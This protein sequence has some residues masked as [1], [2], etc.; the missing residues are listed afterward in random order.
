MKQRIISAVFIAL[1]TIGLILIGG[2]FFKLACF[3]IGAYV[4]REFIM[5]SKKEFNI[6]LYSIMFFTIAMILLFNEYANIIVIIEILFLCT[7]FVN[8]E[9][10]S[11]S[12][13][14][15]T[16]LMSLLIGFGLYFLNFIEQCSRLLTA[17]IIIITYITDVFALFTGMKFGKHKLNERVSPKKTIEGAIGGWLFGAILSFVFA[18]LFDFFYLNTTLIVISSICLPIVSQIGDLVFSAIKRFY[19]VK[20]FSNL[21]PG[22]GGLLDRLD[23]TFFC[24]VFFGVLLVLAV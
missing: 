13:A 21:I 2:N 22:H 24:V 17:Y 9:N 11:F 5:V 18:Y 14:S 4:T 7:L 23:S 3:I 1:T 8:D 12:D 10:V 16:L 20:D 19:N 6:S 15:T